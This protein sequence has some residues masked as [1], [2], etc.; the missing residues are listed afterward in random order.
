MIG[1]KLNA[2]EKY[3]LDNKGEFEVYAI[4][5]SFI[6]K[7]LKN[8]LLKSSVSFRISIESLGMGIYKSFNYEIFERRPSV[9][10]AMEGNMAGANLVQEAKNGKAKSLIYVSGNSSFLSQKAMM[11]KGYANIYNNKKD[12]NKMISTIKKKVGE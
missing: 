11:L 4:V 8:K 10:I 12:L 1:Y 7:S 3:L 6:D 2:Y 5:P 9:L